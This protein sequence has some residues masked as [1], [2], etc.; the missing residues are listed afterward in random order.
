MKLLL[1]TLEDGEHIGVAYGWGRNSTLAQERPFGR[2]AETVCN[3]PKLLV[4]SAAANGSF[5]SNN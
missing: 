1:Q 2:R 5:L 4:H 3:E